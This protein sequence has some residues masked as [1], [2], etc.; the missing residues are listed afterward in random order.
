MRSVGTRFRYSGIAAIFIVLLLACCPGRLSAQGEMAGRLPANTIAYWEWNG[1]AAVLSDATKNHLLQLAFDPQL[2]PL[3]GALI[4]QAQSAN[5]NTSHTAGTP[6]DKPGM[7]LGLPD[8]V[9]LLSN[10]IVLGAVELRSKVTVSSTG[11]SPSPKHVGMFLVYDATGKAELVQKLK[12]AN[13]KGGAWT[14][15]DVGGTQ[16]EYQSTE[17]KTGTDSTYR[18]QAGNYYFVSDQKTVIEDLIGRFARGEKAAGSLTERPEFQKMQ[19][20]MQSGTAMEFYLRVP[21]FSSW[22]DTPGQPSAKILAG[23]HFDKIHA[24]GGS[25]SFAGEATEFRGAVLG[26]TSAGS[27]FDFAGESRTGFVTEPLAKMG[28]A[29]GTSRMNWA[30]GYQWLQGALTGNLPAQQATSVTMAQAMAQAFLGMPIDDALKLFTGEMASV[31]SYTEDGTSQQ[32]FAITIQKPESVLHILRA[33]GGKMIMADDSAGTTTYLDIAYPYRDPAS[34]TQ[35]RKFY[36]VAV[37]PEMLLA[38]PRKEMLRQ[39]TN[40]LAS[41]GGAPTGVLANPEFQQLRMKLPEKLTAM[42][43]ADLTQ[44]P[45]DKI[46]ANFA[47]QME[48]SAKKQNRTTAKS[49]AN[50]VPTPSEQE[51][52]KLLKSIPPN[53]VSS[54][55]HVSVGGWWKDA[56]G[57]YI[58]SYIQ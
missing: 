31:S 5:Q 32:L 8:V 57:I 16:V 54:H 51:A 14:K 30:A 38:A 40:I 33:V 36:Y 21:D 18:A 42:S 23:L 6:Q 4:Q 28:S 20:Y 37:T 45:W 41:K 34:G 27:P 47:V 55:L 26:D 3:W 7:Q 13:A 22:I 46:A 1:S 2:A 19:K 17:T 56:S 9:S 48:E 29:Y 49:T 53:I 43:A 50:A 52:V 15:Y 12:A 24:A 11:N 10:P 39:A 25:L 58:D 44:I 35:R